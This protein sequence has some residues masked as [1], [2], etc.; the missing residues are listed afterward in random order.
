ML[1]RDIRNQARAQRD[2]FFYG[3]KGSV[4]DSLKM[5]F[6]LEEYT[7]PMITRIYLKLLFDGNIACPETGHSR[8]TDKSL[9]VRKRLL[10]SLLSTTGRDLRINIQALPSKSWMMAALRMS[11]PE[12]PL[13][14]LADQAYDLNQRFLFDEITSEEF[15][16]T[17]AQNTAQIELYT[18]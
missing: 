9:R 1:V 7:H 18:E 17:K 5:I 8:T 10:F 15:L 4:Y 13:V 11:L 12:H 2:I 6:Y 3:D 16:R 14:L